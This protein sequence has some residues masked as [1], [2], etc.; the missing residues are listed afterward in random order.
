MTCFSPSWDVTCLNN[1]DADENANG[2]ELSRPEDVP[3]INELRTIL[4]S[5]FRELRRPRIGFVPIRRNGIVVPNVKNA[6]SSASNSP[7]MTSSLM[8]WWLWPSHC[9]AVEVTV[10]TGS[11]HDELHD[12]VVGRSLRTGIHVF[13]I[14]H[15]R[16]RIRPSTRINPSC[17]DWTVKKKT[18]DWILIAVGF[19]LTYWSLHAFRVNGIQSADT[20]N[21]EITGSPRNDITQSSSEFVIKTWQLTSRYRNDIDT[22][23]IRIFVN[24]RH[25]TDCSHDLRCQG[26]TTR[27]LWSC[28]SQWPCPAFVLSSTIRI[29]RLLARPT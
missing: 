18:S 11:Q 15:F 22:T 8:S 13:R 16:Y 3:D 1:E 2:V 27:R 6:S 9:E 19:L 5:S 21:A 17:I 28:G 4:S 29:Q 7:T 12:M 24:R 20:Q 23:D 10:M 14:L 26:R 25:I